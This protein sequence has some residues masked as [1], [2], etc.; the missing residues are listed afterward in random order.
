M[1]VF[2]EPKTVPVRQSALVRS[3]SRSSP[4]PRESPLPRAQ[5]FSL[6][7]SYKT[8]LRTMPAGF[9]FAPQNGVKNKNCLWRL[10]LPVHNDLSFH[11]H[12]KS[13]L[14]NAH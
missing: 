12:S 3:L 14:R 11:I 8:P 1:N 6:M 4:L 13:S 10:A 5:S 2:P 9:I 7:F